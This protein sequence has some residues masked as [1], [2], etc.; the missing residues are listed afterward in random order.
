[1]AK[2]H[3]LQASNLPQSQ[4]FIQPGGSTQSSNSGQ[5]CRTTGLTWQTIQK[6][7]SDAVVFVRP[8]PEQLM[9]ILYRDR[10]L[11]ATPR[12]ADERTTMVQRTQH[13][14]LRLKRA[15]DFGGAAAGLALLSP[16]YGI[17][18][19]LIKFHDFGPVFHRRR[20]VGANGA[21]DAF[22][23]RTMYPNAD[24]ILERSP[25][26]RQEYEN[27]FKLKDDPRVTPLGRWLRRYSVDELPQLFNVLVGQMSL[28][29]P[30]MITAPELAKYGEHEELL[31]TVKPGLTGYWQVYGRQEVSYEE[32]VRMDVTYIRTWSLW[33]DLHLLALTPW[34]VICG[35]GAY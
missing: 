12:V 7:Y 14:Q 9:S 11:S 10:P 23:F 1:V 18:A 2:L 29:G 32:R 31:M 22:K 33:K 21:F 24:A 8:Q 6:P 34:R 19:A 13:W 28:V 3:A 30:R 25:E 35:R 27:S 16:V 17:V 15:I 5:S 4:R 26:L 20:V